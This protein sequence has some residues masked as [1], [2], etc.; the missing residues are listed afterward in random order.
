[1]FFEDKTSESFTIPT[2]SLGLTRESLG[3]TG[4]WRSQDSEISNITL[5]TISG[6]LFS[7]QYENEKRTQQKQKKVN[8]VDQ[9]CGLM[10]WK[11]PKLL[12]NQPEKPTADFLKFAMDKE[13]SNKHFNTNAVEKEFSL[14]ALSVRQKKKMNKVN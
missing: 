9:F 3:L 4:K 8:E 6:K 12:A 13:T 10:G 7:V 1:M 11:D 5:P 2:V 14:K